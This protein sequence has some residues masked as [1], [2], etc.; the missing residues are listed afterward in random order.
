MNIKIAPFNL[1]DNIRI[2]YFIFYG[3]FI[4]T[5]RFNEN[6]KEIPKIIKNKGNKIDKNILESFE[7]ISKE[8]L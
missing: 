4:I 3:Q 1:I 6:I 7:K 2:I 5:Y 8:V